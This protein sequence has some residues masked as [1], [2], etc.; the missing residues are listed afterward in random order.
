MENPKIM[1]IVPNVEHGMHYA[2]DDDIH[3]IYLFIYLFNKFFFK[4]NREN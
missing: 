2:Y 3:P 4:K 1:G